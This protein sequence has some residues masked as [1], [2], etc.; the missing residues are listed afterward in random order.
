[1]VDLTGF[2]RASQRIFNILSRVFSS[3]LN[4]LYH[5]G[6]IT[7]FLLFID[8][9]SGIYLFIFYK[10]DPRY[11]Y[12]SVEAIS[13][14]FIGNIMRGIHRYSSDALVLSTFLH[15]LHVIITDRFRL[16]R[17]VAWFTGI[18]SLIIFVV[19]GLTGYILVWD[20][21]A[22]IA[23]IFTGKFLSFLPIFGGDIMS[24]FFGTD[25]KYLG[26]LFR[27]LLYFHIAL[28]IVIVFI[29]W[30]HVMR[31]ARARIIPPKYLWVVMTFIL[32]LI[33]VLLPAKSDPEASLISIPFEVST[34]WFYF[35][36]LPL[37]KMI[38]LSQM[39][40]LLTGLFIL[41]VLFPWLIKGKRNPPVNMNAERCVGCEQCYIDCPYE[42]VIMRR[43]GDK[44]RSYLLDRKCAGCGI[45]LGACSFGAIDFPLY[46]FE[47]LLEKVKEISPQFV[48]YHCP[49]AA[50]PPERDGLLIYQVPCA[51]AV[52]PDHVRRLLKEGVKGVLIIACEEED[53]HFRE[54]TKWLIERY[55]RR[56]KPFLKEDVDSSRIKIILAP[57]VRDITS[58]VESFIKGMEDGKENKEIEV[59]SF[60]KINYVFASILLLVPAL[61]LYPLSTHKVSYYPEDKSLLILSFKYRSSP[62][63]ARSRSPIMVQ[64]LLNDKEVFSKTFNPRGIR[65]DASIFVYQEIML[66]PGESIIKIRLQET[67]FPEKSKELTLHEVF[68][69]GRG[70]V[71]TYDDVKKELLLLKKAVEM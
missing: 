20:T 32:V 38:P 9:L 59:S 10:I 69:K 28:T 56:R 36:I 17:W 63:L 50:R 39:W 1:M 65:K 64:V 37:I 62:S 2:H 3:R 70:S 33:S 34:D 47:G 35:F 66:P 24:T 58:D 22:Q 31:N 57:S 40:L 41:F 13:S 48:A 19:I 51:G 53:C 61:L 46:R 8:S 4:P 7:V 25:I 6:A 44:K 15:F 12:S 5:L 49:F 16:F 68:L 54:G 67:F 52:H 18:I 30:I 29:L 45:C 27:M 23:G 55:K 71:V 42:A 14:G 26:G 21:K 11:S 43:Q 60:K